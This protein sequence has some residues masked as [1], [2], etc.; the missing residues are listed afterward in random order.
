MRGF[1]YMSASRKKN[2]NKEQKEAL[3]KFAETVG[4]NNYEER[5]KFFKKF[6]K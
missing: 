1:D 4:E 2:L 6:K 3:K 5:K